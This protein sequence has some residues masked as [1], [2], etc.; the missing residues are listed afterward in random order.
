M[1]ECDFKVRNN[2][3]SLFDLILE[4]NSC[5]CDMNW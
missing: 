1:N 4:Q 3:M 2:L 5:D